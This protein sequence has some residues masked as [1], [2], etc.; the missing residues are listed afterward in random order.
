[1]KSLKLSVAMNGSKWG[2]KPCLINPHGLPDLP[3]S[4]A[5]AISDTAAC[6]ALGAR[7]FHIHSRGQDDE[8]VADKLWYEKYMSCF[9]QR[10][11]DASICL[12]TSRSGEVIDQIDRREQTLRT[13]WHKDE[14]ALLASAE[15][16][17]LACLEQ[18]D[19]SL[20]P[21]FVTGF[22]A[23]E[24]RIYDDTADIGH[25]I[26]AQ[27]SAVTHLFYNQL[28]NQLKTLKVKQELEITTS[29]SIDIIEK[30]QEENLLR[31]PVRIVFL[32]EFTPSLSGWTWDEMGKLVTRARKIIKK[33]GY[34][35]DIVM[36]VILR[37]GTPDLEALRRYWLKFSVEHPE[38]NTV[39]IGLED[40]PVLFG[41]PTT[42]ASLTKLT[43][44]LLREFGAEITPLV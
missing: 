10:F 34:D 13:T 37:P 9:R 25:V 27:Q 28:T 12:A 42:N 32:P 18:A 31:T 40:C 29:C 19:Q 26:S 30:L 44:T 36:G 39:R 33:T 2:K 14:C 5:E 41:K 11:H 6:Y 35:G 38:I 22:T 7:Q 24:V 16:A 20:L 3:C 15:E 8:H 21:D 43:C 17:R 1:M 23:T 4:V